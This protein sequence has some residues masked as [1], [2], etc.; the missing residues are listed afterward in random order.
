MRTGISSRATSAPARVPQRCSLGTG[1]RNSSD[2]SISFVHTILPHCGHQVK[3]QVPLEV[4]PE[5]SQGIV[6]ASIWLV[7]QG[8]RRLTAWES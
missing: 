3:H 5:T 6:P 2:L 7:H 1:H 8:I 4:M